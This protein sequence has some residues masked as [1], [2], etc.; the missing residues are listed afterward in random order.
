MALERVGDALF[1][2]GRPPPLLSSLSQHLIIVTLYQPLLTFLY[3]LR[4]AVASRSSALSLLR[5]HSLL[6]DP[7]LSSSPFCVIPSCLLCPPGKQLTHS[8]ILPPILTQQ[9]LSK[10]DSQSLERDLPAVKASGAQSLTASSVSR[11]IC[12]PGIILDRALVL[13]FYTSSSFRWTRASRTTNRTLL[14]HL[15]HLFSA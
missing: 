10:L 6:L 15:N 11:T 4:K 2:F 9:P 12:R 1:L 5:Y 3:P 14:I 8:L 13:T 7:V